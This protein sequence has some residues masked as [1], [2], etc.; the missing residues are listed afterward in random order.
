MIRLELEHFMA[1]SDLVSTSDHEWNSSK[2]R[3]K[4]QTNKIRMRCGRAGPHSFSSAR[5]VLGHTEGRPTLLTSSR[6]TG[7][8]DAS[9]T[10][11]KDNVRRT[12]DICEHGVRFNWSNQR[13]SDGINSRLIYQ[14]MQIQELLR[15]EKFSALSSKKLQHIPNSF[16]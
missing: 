8:Q 3:C 14:I 5:I 10:N 6:K 16:L 4:C 15:E 13:T 12:V 11:I 9:T 1:C 2:C 7:K